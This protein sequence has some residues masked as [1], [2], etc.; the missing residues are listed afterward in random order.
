MC[1]S[2]SG[3]KELVCL[4][5]TNPVHGF[6]EHPQFRGSGTDTSV[7]TTLQFVTGDVN[8]TIEVAAEGF[9]LWFRLNMFSSRSFFIQARVWPV[10]EEPLFSNNYTIYQRSSE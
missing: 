9:R 2:V 7:F 10:T 8:A 4:S 6:R 3:C 5:L 1:C